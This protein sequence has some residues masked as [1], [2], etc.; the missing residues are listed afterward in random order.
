MKFSELKCFFYDFDGVMTDNHVLVDEYGTEAALVNRSDG[1]A[2]ER[3]KER[4]IHQVIISTERNSIVKK[5]AEKLG[6]P[7]INGVSDKGETLIQYCAEKGFLLSEVMF[8]GN[9]LN[10]LPALKAAGVTGAP[11]NAEAE[12]L[13]VVQWV[14][15]RGG[16]EGVI[17]D[18]YRH[19]DEEI[20]KNG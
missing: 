5:R 2:I 9:D 19:I 4:G 14:S 16:G 20:P 7:V 8:I 13:Q 17:R 11:A 12:I 18:L 3:I 6:I 1:Y 15:S 10:D